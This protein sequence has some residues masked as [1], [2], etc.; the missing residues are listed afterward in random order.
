L[1]TDSF[2]AFES[3]FQNRSSIEK[4]VKKAE[5]LL[6]DLGQLRREMHDMLQVKSVLSE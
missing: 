5:D 6:Q 1:R 3:S 2:P 4:T